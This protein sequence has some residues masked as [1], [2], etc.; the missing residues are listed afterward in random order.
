MTIKP[1]IS[2]ESSGTEFNLKKKA[3]G[4]KGGGTYSGQKIT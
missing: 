4:G 2:V 1:N 3:G